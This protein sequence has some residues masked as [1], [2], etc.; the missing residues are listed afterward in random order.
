MRKFLH[1]LPYFLKEALSL[2]RREPLAHF[3]A[4]LSVALI[5]TLVST[6]LIVS[7]VTEGLVDFLVGEATFHV[8]YEEGQGENLYKELLSIEGVAAVNRVDAEE[9]AQKMRDLLGQEHEVLSMLDTNPFSAFLEVEIAL[10]RRGALYDEILALSGVSSLRDNRKALDSLERIASSANSITTALVTGITLIA[11]VLISHLIR[12][13]FH[14]HRETI[15]T[16]RLL[17]APETFV[18]IPFFV[19]ALSIALLGTILALMASELVIGPTLQGLLGP[20]PFLPPTLFRASTG[21]L[22]QQLLPLSL[23]LGLGGSGFG[24]LTAKKD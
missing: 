14:D 3:L 21:Q 23:L 18:A 19:D 2:Y 7:G 8:F 6:G 15:D 9:A 10:D 1:N 5:F 12:V 11:V 13:G 22:W 16:L 24:Y 17:G 4:I 20:L